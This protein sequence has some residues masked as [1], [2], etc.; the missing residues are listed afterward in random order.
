MCYIEGFLKVA[1]T[2]DLAVEQRW[3]HGEKDIWK[4]ER[5]DS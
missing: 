3:M 4:R 2:A 5:P 1:K